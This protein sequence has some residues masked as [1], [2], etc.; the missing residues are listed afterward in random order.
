MKYGPI[1]C[2]IFSIIALAFAGYLTVT[3][4][5]S[6][7]KDYNEPKE[8]PVEVICISEAG[9]TVAVYKT[10]YKPTIYDSNGVVHVS[11]LKDFETGKEI[12]IRTRGTV[13]CQ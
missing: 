3:T 5:L 1:F 2:G 10:L 4:L 13:I 9:D 12:D 11:G 8:K 7:Y 6:N